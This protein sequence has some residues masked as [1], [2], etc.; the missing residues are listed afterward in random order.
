MQHAFTT[1]YNGLTRV[2]HTKVW[3]C[4]PTVSSEEHGKNQELKEYEAIWDTGATNSAI[5]KQVISDLDL[6]P[7]GLVEVR[8]ADGKSVT[9]TFLVSIVLPN[10]VMFGQVRVSKVNLIADDN[11]KDEDKPQLL[12][13]MDIIG[14]GDFVVSNYNGKTCLTFRLPS[15]ER[16]NF[17]P[18]AKMHNII[19]QKKNRGS[20]KGGR[21]R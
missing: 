11:Q 3:V 21:R 12:I 5:T 14:A 18:Q 9:E 17:V 7:T 16:I 2:L 13:G 10:R 15:M 8:H 19:E 6:K 4:I 20:F 1:D